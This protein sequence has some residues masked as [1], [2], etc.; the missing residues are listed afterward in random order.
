MYIDDMAKVLEELKEV[1]DE[2]SRLEQRR[3]QLATVARKQGVPWSQIG[4]VLGVS[5]QA[6]QQRQARLQ[7]GELVGRMRARSDLNESAAME[8]AL[9]AQRD[10]RSRR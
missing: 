2:I 7:F 9:E 4:T 3:D 10:A 5:K 1:A 6:A 8:L